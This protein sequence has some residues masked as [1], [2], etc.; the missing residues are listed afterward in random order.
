MP[1]GSPVRGS[2]TISPPGRD[3]RPAG[4]PGELQG[5][6]VGEDHVPVVAVD[7]NGV[8]RRRG[9]DPVPAGQLRRGEPLVVPVAV[10]DPVAGSERA[11]LGRDAGGE[12]VAARR[13]AETDAAQREAA[14][15]KV[16]VAVDEPRQDEPAPEV[17]DGRA[18]PRQGAAFGLRAD[19]E[20]PLPPDGHGVG[21][22][23]L[24][25]S[26]PYRRVGQNEVGHVPSRGPRAARPEHRD[27]EQEPGQ[28]ADPAPP[29]VPTFHAPFHGE[30]YIK[31][32]P[33]E[34]NRPAAVG[35]PPRMW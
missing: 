7:A 24:R 15:Q 34:I 32:F 11:G 31:E 22:G 5:Q 29:D 1:V 12:L 20:D 30:P 10:E 4:D 35:R 17:D 26:R 23:P 28:R 2:L 25:V 14:G 18:L 27:R 16:R 8:G 9:V 19:A 21:P 6:G 13:V 33:G 3:G